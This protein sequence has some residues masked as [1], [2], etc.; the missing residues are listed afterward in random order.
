MPSKKSKR[1]DK[2]AS[3][4]KVAKARIRNPLA[5]QREIAKE[6][7]I[8]NWTVARADKVLEQSGAEDPRIAGL[9]DLDIEIEML[10]TKEIKRRISDDP[11]KVTNADITRFNESATKR[12]VIF[13]ATKDKD[14]ETPTGNINITWTL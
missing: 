6:V 8:G 7:G 9:L 1:A 5:T 10:A 13:W 4:A 3:I 2:K 12:R 14:S 11:T